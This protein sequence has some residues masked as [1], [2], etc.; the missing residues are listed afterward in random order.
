MLDSE[1]CDYLLNTVVMRCTMQEAAMFFGY[2]L[3]QFGQTRRQWLASLFCVF[4]WLL[5]EFLFFPNWVGMEWAISPKWSVHGYQLILSI[6]ETIMMAVSIGQHHVAH[7][8][9]PVSMFC[10]FFLQF[11]EF[12]QSVYE[13]RLVFFFPFT[14]VLLEHSGGKSH[15]FCS[16]VLKSFLLRM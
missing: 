8:A 7:M 13:M 16:L 12:L 1:T 5:I 10:L 15:Y 6:S 2:Y 4:H 14:A 3:H 9:N 11:I